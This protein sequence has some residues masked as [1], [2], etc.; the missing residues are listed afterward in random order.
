[1]LQEKQAV[2]ATIRAIT[3]GSVIVKQTENQNKIK[4]KRNACLLAYLCGGVWVRCAA[5]LALPVF[6]GVCALQIPLETRKEDG[7]VRTART[8][9]LLHTSTRP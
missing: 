5:S 9:M 4:K 1:M 8:V 7:Q 3:P 2:R 6:S